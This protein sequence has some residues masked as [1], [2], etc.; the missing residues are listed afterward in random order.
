MHL[1][2][3]VQ[4]SVRVAGIKVHFAEGESIHTE[5]SYKFTPAKIKAIA[6]ECEFELTAQWSDARNLFSDYL[7]TAI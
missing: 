4:Q 3:T 6:R 1:V 2:S 5:N 7:L